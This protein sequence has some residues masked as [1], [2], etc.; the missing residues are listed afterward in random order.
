MCAHCGGTFRPSTDGQRFCSLICG[1]KSPNRKGPRPDLRRV[2]R[3]PYDELVATLAADGYEAT[4]R[5]FGV[6]GNAVRKWRLNYEREAG[7]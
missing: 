3:P 4:G 6:S 2:E 1:W 5:R 7:G